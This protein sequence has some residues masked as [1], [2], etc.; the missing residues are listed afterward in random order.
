MSSKSEKIHMSVRPPN[1]LYFQFH[2]R[3]RLAGQSHNEVLLRLMAGY[4]SGI[5]EVDGI[6][7]PSRD[8]RWRHLA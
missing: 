4:A 3:A 6:P 1:D 2:E 5:F 8:K 7:S